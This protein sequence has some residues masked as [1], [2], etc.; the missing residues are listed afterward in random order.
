MD[1]RQRFRR[2]IVTA[3]PFE[4]IAARLQIPT[5]IPGDSGNSADFLEVI[6]V[7]LQ[8]F[9][10]HRIVLDGHIGRDELLS[11][12]L[13]YVAPEAQIF[14][15]CAPYLAAPMHTCPTDT[16]AKNER[17]VSSVRCRNVADVMTYRYRL[18]GQRLKLVTAN[19]ILE[20]IDNSGIL[21]IRRGILSRT[22]LERHDRQTGIGQCLGHDGAGPTESDDDSVNR[23]QYSRHHA[24][25]PPIDT[26]P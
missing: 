24:R 12:A 21:E 11:V 26:G 17:S 13:L 2:I 20:F 15:R 10:A 4:G 1:R 5:E 25:L 23:L 9:E 8:L 19:R 6:E 18:L 7:R 14:R 22:A 16:V 3:G